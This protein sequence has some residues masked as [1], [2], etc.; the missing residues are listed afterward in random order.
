[1]KQRTIDHAVKYTGIGLHSGREVNLELQPAEEGTGI[2]YYRVDVE[3]TS[4]LISME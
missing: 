2:V 4:V 3:G 1:M